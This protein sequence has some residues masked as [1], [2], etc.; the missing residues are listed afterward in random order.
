MTAIAGAAGRVGD[1]RARVHQGFDVPFRHGLLQDVLAA[2]RDDH[3]HA[4]CDLPSRQD[5]R[6]NGKIFD[7]AVRTGTDEGLVDF[8]L[9]Q[10]VCRC[11]VVRHLVWQN[12]KRLEF[13][14]VDL[15]GFLIYCVGV[16]VDRLV[17]LRSA[18]VEI[19]LQNVVVT[20]QREFSRQFRR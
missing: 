18:P 11:R 4:G 9:T 1:D 6:G 12:D 3:A 5:F 19:F 2:G 14:N 16:G 13:G 10:R 17:G 7:T 20:E 15:D 8:G